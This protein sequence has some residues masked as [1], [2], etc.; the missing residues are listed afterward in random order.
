[1]GSPAQVVNIDRLNADP[2]LTITHIKLQKH[3]PDH[4]TSSSHAHRHNYRFKRLHST[5][6]TS[7]DNSRNFIFKRHGLFTCTQVELELQ[8]S[9]LFKKSS[10]YEQH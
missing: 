7:K 6:S 4:L 9:M 8:A 2:L 5:I 3:V 1:M 10:G